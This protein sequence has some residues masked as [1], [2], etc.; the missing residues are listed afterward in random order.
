MTDSQETEDRYSRRDQ[1]EGE[2]ELID[3]LR[4]MWKWKWLIIGGT[5]VC[6]L[7]FAVYD[8]T[9]P[10]VSMYKASAL[11]EIDPNAKLD[12]LDKI[13][14]MIEYGIFNQQVLNELSDLQGI[15]KPG[16]LSFNVKI[17][18]DLN[19]LDVAYKT[20]N[21]DLGKA[22]LNLLI[23]QLEQAYI[24]KARHQ[25]E[26]KLTEISMHI[27]QVGALYEERRLIKDG[28]AQTTKVLQEAQPYS[29]KLLAKREARFF[30]SGDSADLINTFMQ[31][32][33]V[34]QVID[35]PLVLRERI[36]YLVSKRNFISSKIMSEI[37]TIKDMAMEIKSLK[38]AKEPYVSDE[39]SFI[40]K[41]TSEI[42]LLR[43]DRDK[44]TGVIVKQ[45]PS[46]S[47]IFTKYK[48]QR[49][50]LLVGIAGFMLTAFI[51]VFIEYIKNASKRTR[52]TT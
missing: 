49:N 17:Y 42:E 13:K 19:M 43:H 47:P 38:I 39:E 34:N 31:D 33:A 30:D 4:F 5:L 32:A 35:Y 46:A 45:P 14:S 21:A 3:Y 51:A 6:M 37:S 7:A 50:V 15:S 1:L 12:P 52:Q 20:P 44:I 27:A 8:F 2:V 10:V 16:S 41:L 25:F 11:V 40:L 36:H 29:D 18:K 24:Q 22:V 28:I 26:K 9:R 23:K 48:T